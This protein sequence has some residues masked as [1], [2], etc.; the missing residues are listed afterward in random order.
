MRFFYPFLGKS[1]DLKYEWQMRKDGN[2]FEN[3]K[4]NH[5]KFGEGNVVE[6]DGTHI[7]IVFS[8]QN[9]EKTFAYPTV[10][11]KFVKFESQDAQGKVTDDLNSAK[12]ETAK[13]N[14]LKRLMYIEQEKRRKLEQTKK[15]SRKR[16]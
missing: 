1:R 7:R 2:M 16:A 5:V 8:C 3:E 9:V 10:F 4:V 15:T 6:C 13:L 14:N 12:E 11:E